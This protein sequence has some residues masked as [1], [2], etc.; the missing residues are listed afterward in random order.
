MTATEKA[1]KAAF[2]VLYSTPGKIK[3]ST[4]LELSLD[5]LIKN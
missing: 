4:S 3:K 2:P 5:S 1:L